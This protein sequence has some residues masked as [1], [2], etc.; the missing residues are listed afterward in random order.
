MDQLLVKEIANTLSIKDKQIEAVLSLL[1]EGNTIP[2]IARYRKEVTGG[3]DEEQI[4][5]IHKSWEYGV[6]LLKRKEDV[7][8]L[9]EEKGM[10]TDEL[11]NNILKS[12]KLQRRLMCPCGCMKPPILVN[13][14]TSSPFFV[15]MAGM[16]VWNGRFPPARTLG[17]PERREKFAPRFCS[18]NPVPGATRPE[19][20]CM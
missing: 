11:R 7:I 20:K 17:E 1:D 2:F 6:N 3:L 14:A 10:M 13:V 16:M 18:T 19:P 5:E 9:I 15:I 4:N 12:T 8:R